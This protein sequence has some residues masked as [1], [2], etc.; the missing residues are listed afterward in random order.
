[1][2]RWWHLLVSSFSMTSF[3]DDVARSLSANTAH[4]FIAGF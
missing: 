1:L 3:F 2:C 4:I